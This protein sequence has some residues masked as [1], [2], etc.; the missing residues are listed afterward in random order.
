MQITN[1]TTYIVKEIETESGNIYLR[2]SSDDWRQVIGEAIE[3]LYCCEEIEKTFQEYLNQMQKR[4]RK[5]VKCR[6]H[7]ETNTDD[8]IIQTYPKDELC[9]VNT[10]C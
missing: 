9:A 7:R 5:Q 6:I 2:H 4:K 8:D 10:V 3:P 1:I